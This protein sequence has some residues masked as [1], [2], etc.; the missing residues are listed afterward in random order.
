MTTT[1]WTFESGLQP[2]FSN[3]VQE[4]RILEINWPKVKL[5]DECEW[6]KALNEGRE[7]PERLWDDYINTVQDCETCEFERLEILENGGD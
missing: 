6:C 5:D 1:T 2:T 4:E 3:E 7:P